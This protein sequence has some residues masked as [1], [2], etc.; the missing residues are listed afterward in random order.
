M[1][2]KVKAVRGFLWTATGTIGSGLISFL[3]TI[4]LARI[5]GPYE[6]GLLEIIIVFTTISTVF[7]D[8]GFS[9]AIIRDN[10][11]SQKDLSSVFFLQIA[12]AIIIYILLFYLAPPIAHFFD[13]NELIPL[14]RFVF[15]TLIFD[16]FSL[17]QNANLN[18]QLKFKPFALASIIA[19][20]LSG[21][22]AVVMAFNNFGVWAL[23]SN[24]VLT[25]LLRSVLLWLQV[26]WRPSFQI[27]SK[28]IQ[29]YFKFGVNLLIQ[30]LIDKV[31]SNLESILIGRV[32]SKQSLGYFAQSRK[33]NAFLSQP[34]TNV[35]QKVTYPSLA[36][37]ADQPERLKEGYR[38]V[39]GITMFCIAP[40]MIFTI[41]SSENFITVV[42]G[43]KW[44]KSSEYLRLW[45]IW[46]VFY[47]VSSVYTN[48]FLVKGKSKLLLKI[49]SIKQVLRIISV[50][51]LVKIGIMPM[52]WGIIAVAIASTFM[53]TYFGGRLIMYK[54]REMFNDLTKTFITSLISAL[55]VYL[56]TKFILNSNYYFGF[57]VQLIV[58]VSTYFILNRF[59]VK[60]IYFF[61]VKEILS[62]LLK[63][64][65]NI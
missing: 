39:I 23:T 57:V 40:L 51:M 54:Q 9:Q 2:I 62:S 22:I 10:N 27:S 52:L 59:V 15:L 34:T 43:E 30:G 38:R 29:K 6:F 46:G 44:L 17:V 60:N 21:A 50:I 28:S 48:V 41:V 61:E 20:L 8:S 58:M 31:V 56:T 45:A 65:N 19:I 3:V 55:M 47:P 16:S 13:A 12:I 64:N 42:F 24:F 14:T 63:K 49:S 33:F 36:K 32:Y 5:L 53:Y 4:I 37:I 1:S 7:I 25:S 35:V 18:R 11:P 26:K